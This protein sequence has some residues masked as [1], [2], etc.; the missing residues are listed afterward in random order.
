MFELTIPAVALLAVGALL[1]GITKTALPGASTVAVA[2]F[3]AV[4]PA[5]SSTATLL[6]LLIVGD[7]M[8]LLIY[9]RHADWRA[10]VRLAPAV[11]TGLVCGAVFLWLADDA[12]V[13]R[14]IGVILLVL[15]AFTL[16][17]R[18][19][20]TD[21]STFS[22]AAARAMSWGY[23]SLGGFT[24]MVANAGGPVMS[25]YFLA[26]GFSV[27]AFLGTS[28]WFFAI[29]NLVKVPIAVGL[30]LITPHTIALDAVLAPVVLVGGLLGW[31]IAGRIPQR[32][33]EIAV[34][35]LTVVG[36]AYLLV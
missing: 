18:R 10:L 36:A 8:A 30:G 4:L 7:M 28:A 2:M 17:L 35:V 23:G 5:K 14:A 34:L 24:T 20:R 32:V 13:R 22:P 25:M 3:A 12:G 33:F 31:L 29:I 15:I 1:V 6:L 21:A 9:R 16:W 26:R 27:K 11:L 19:R